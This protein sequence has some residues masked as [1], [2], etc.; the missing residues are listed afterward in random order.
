MSQARYFISRKVQ[1]VPVDN[2]LALTKS[3]KICKRSSF[4]TLIRIVSNW[5][6]TLYAL[7][8]N[9]RHKLAQLITAWYGERRGK[10]EKELPARYT[11]KSQSRAETT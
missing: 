3:S 5:S 2:S 8:N 4:R 7:Y 11:E 1:M 10:M 9:N 6:Y